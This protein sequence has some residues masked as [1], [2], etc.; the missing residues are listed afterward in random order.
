MPSSNIP[1]GILLQKNQSG[2]DSNLNDELAENFLWTGLDG[3]G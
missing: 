2:F 1:W 3:L